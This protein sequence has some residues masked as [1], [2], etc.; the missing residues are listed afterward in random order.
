MERNTRIFLI[1]STVWGPV[2]G[3]MEY[4][5]QSVIHTNATTP[6]N[7]W[8]KAA[9]NAHLPKSQNSAGKSNVYAGDISHSLESISRVK[10]W[11]DMTSQKCLYSNQPRLSLAHQACL[12]WREKRRTIGGSSGGV[13]EVSRLEGEHFTLYCWSHCDWRI[14]H[15]LSDSVIAAW[16]I[17][18][19][20]Y[21]LLL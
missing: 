7:Y 6:L 12:A 15:T 19:N 13:S 20:C 18:K 2:R 14:H 11:P 16:K 17:M 10:M 1:Y 5:V 4:E 3:Y 21:D 9:L 8:A